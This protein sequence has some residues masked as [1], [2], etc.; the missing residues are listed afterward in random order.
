[1]LLEWVPIHTATKTMVKKKKLVV[2]HA[3]DCL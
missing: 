3:T 1:M 2:T